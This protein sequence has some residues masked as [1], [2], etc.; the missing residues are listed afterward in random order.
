MSF[1]LQRA[2]N[3]GRL[4]WDFAAT[5]FPGSPQRCDRARRRLIQRLGL[6][7]GLP[8]KLGQLL[9]LPELRDSDHAYSVLTEGSPGLAPR[10]ALDEIRRCLAQDSSPTESRAL[11]KVFRYVDPKGIGASLG[12]VHRAQLMDGTRVAVKIQFPGILD[13]VDTDLHALGWLTEPVGGLRRGFDGAA[14]R[15]EIGGMLRSELD[16]RREADH[17]EAYAAAVR[18]LPVRVPRVFREYSGPRLLTMTW[19]DGERLDAAIRWPSEDRA[20]VAEILAELFFGSLMGWGLLHAD[21]HPGNY[22]FSRDGGAVRVGLLDFGCVKRV[23]GRLARSLSDLVRAGRGGWLDSASAFEAFAGMGFSVEALGRLRGKLEAIARC[24]IAPLVQPRPLRIAEW[25]LGDRL[26]EILGAD[27]MVFRT[28]G[29]PDFIFILRA[30]HGLLHQL[31][32]LDVAVPW[33]EVWDRVVADGRAGHFGEEA[34]EEE[35]EEVPCLAAQLRLQIVDRG[36]TKVDLS[37]PARCV[38]QLEDLMPHGLP[39]RL[40]GRGWDVQRIVDESRCRGHAP[41]ELFVCDEGERR[42]RVWLA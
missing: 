17:L 28:A 31:R 42:V 33:Q 25:R 35:P 24:L 12:Q 7:H 19:M 23:P 5:R 32:A 39:E 15:A 9:A 2:A 14:Y 21:P 20:R 37:F 6:M 41:A 3:L 4:A 40:R 38:N 30:W 11:S 16:Y 29:P 18:H 34:V 1:S 8:Q 26:V 22:R 13:A 36:Q 27:R 10:D